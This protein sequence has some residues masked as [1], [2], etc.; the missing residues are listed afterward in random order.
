MADRITKTASDWSLWQDD[1]AARDPVTPDFVRAADRRLFRVRAAL[2]GRPDPSLDG[3]TWRWTREASR[4]Q[5][6]VFLVRC[7]DR[8]WP[9]VAAY[10]ELVPFVRTALP[11]GVEGCAGLP[12]ADARLVLRV[13]TELAGALDRL[14]PDGRPV[15]LSRS[16]VGAGCTALVTAAVLR[17]L[18][19][20][21]HPDA[22]DLCRVAAADASAAFE[23]V[24]PE[25][26]R[27]RDA[28]RVVQAVARDLETLYPLNHLDDPIDPTEAGPY[29]RLWVREPYA[30]EIAPLM[31][32]AVALVRALTSPGGAPILGTMPTVDGPT[33]GQPDSSPP[34]LAALVPPLAASDSGT[35]PGQDPRVMLAATLN[36]GA[37]LREIR[38]ARGLTQK[39][40][41]ESAGLTANFWSLVEN[42]H[43]SLSE[44][45]LNEVAQ[46]LRIPV[47]LILLLAVRMPD[48]HVTSHLQAMQEAVR[49]LLRP[50]G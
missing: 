19:E 37:A 28:A 5:R 43:R 21:Y 3:L 15:E 10:P 38:E 50:E 23:A 20:P 2:G 12:P 48:G 34:E 17:T 18:A 44:P 25:L 26:H 22:L 6:L 40:A 39:E 11:A 9:L 27:S 33:K 47:P 42:G 16:T 24:A 30:L 41:A 7:L 31:A 8:V 35:G 46:H 1:T 14:V 4:T 32:E 13:W 29:G 45:A 49:E 36:L